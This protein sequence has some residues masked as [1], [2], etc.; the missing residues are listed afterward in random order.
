VVEPGIETHPVARDAGEQAHVPQ[1]FA[2]LERAPPE[3]FDDP[4]EGVVVTRWRDAHS[5]HVARD[6]EARVVDP[7]GPAQ[8]GAGFDEPLPEVPGQVQASGD[9]GAHLVQAHSAVLGHEGAA[10]QQEQ[11][12]DVLRPSRLRPQHDQV[13]RAQPIDHFV[14]T[15]G[16]TPPSHT[17][18]APSGAEGT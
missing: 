18:I 16:L 5:P 14:T 11:R 17:A 7:E 2:A 15:S 3:L 8:P 9:E 1:R 12:A 13:F 4:E 6:R 10:L